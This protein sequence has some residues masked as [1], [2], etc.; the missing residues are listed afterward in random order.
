MSL[1]IV[2]RVR[3]NVHGTIDLSELENVVIDHEIFQRLRR[4][5]QTAFLSY[6][7]PGATHSRFEHSLGVLHLSGIAWNKLT[8]NQR[9]L[10]ETVG[11]NPAFAEIEKKSK[12]INGVLSPTFSNSNQIFES[13]YNLQ[14]IRL[15]AL[16]HDV[17]HPPFS[18][19]GERFLPTLV[20]VLKANESKIPSYLKSY[21]EKKIE[22]NP[23]EHA[24]HEIFSILLIDKILRET[25]R[26]NPSLKLEVDP[27][28]VVSVI[29]PDISPSSNSPLNSLGIYKLLNE[30][31]AGEV[32]IDR[33]DYL[34]RDSR[35][36]GVVYGVFDVGRILDG[37]CIYLDPQDK[38]LHLAISHSS[39]P[40]FED[41]LRARQSMYQ[42]VYFHKT[43]AS[44]EAMIQSIV[45]RL[46]KWTLPADIDTYVSYDEYN[47]GHALAAAAENK[48]QDV[49]E[50]KDFDQT[51]KN[52]LFRRVL[53]KLVY[54]LTDESE[55]AENEAELKIKKICNHLTKN[56]IIFEVVKSS[57]YLTRFR[58]RS[59][60]EERS[61]NYLRLIK[62][63]SRKIPVVSPIEDHSTMIRTVTK[64]RFFVHRIYVESGKNEAGI[65]HVDY[66]AHLIATLDFF[67]KKSKLP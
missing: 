46:S 65:C 3:G 25:Y 4:I 51:L 5:S 17:G 22:I 21:F 37:L 60:T 15:A 6:V 7:F 43:A 55:I 19:S 18:H 1:E 67:P 35:E 34:L 49:Y 41:Y 66:S 30:L 54:E 13:D 50:K 20:E 40:A 31:I 14:V 53:W 61:R 38:S 24:R 39:L 58:P 16:L 10:A 33:M 26:D 12:N 23:K 59:S 47:I 62:K 56:K 27:Q 63:D 64:R 2:R 11:K 28:D 57:T 8:I 32:D 45:S 48:I 44:A 29:C 36:C 42:Q 52:L 9:R